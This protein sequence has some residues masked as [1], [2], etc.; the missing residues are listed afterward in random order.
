MRAYQKQYG[1]RIVRHLVYPR[2]ERSWYRELSQICIL[3]VCMSLLL[4]LCNS[5]N[6][7]LV[8][9][10]CSRHLILKTEVDWGE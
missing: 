4:C 1:G 8:L 3:R 6:Q 10:V 2:V 7:A 5:E 9:P